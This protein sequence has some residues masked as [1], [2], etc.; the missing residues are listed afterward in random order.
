[1][2]DIAQL[3]HNALTHFQL[4]DWQVS[5]STIYLGSTDKNGKWIIEKWDTSAGTHRYEYGTSDYATA[6]T[7]RALLTYGYFSDEIRF[8]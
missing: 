1:M 4:T 2:S 8:G 7:G 3:L 5:G 6:W